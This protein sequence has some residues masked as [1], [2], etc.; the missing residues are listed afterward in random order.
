MRHYAFLYPLWISAA[1][2][3]AALL[4]G[5]P[6]ASARPDRLSAA[7]AG[8]RALAAL[9]ADDPALWARHEV[10][11][12]AYA[13]RGELGPEGRWIILC[14]APR[15]DLDRAVVVEIDAR[16]GRIVRI[17]PVVK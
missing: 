4:S 15:R 2:T 17:R 7:A 6:D 12:A 3:A 14:D 5:V 9:A 1:I 11:N 13:R 8:E 16:S 10:V